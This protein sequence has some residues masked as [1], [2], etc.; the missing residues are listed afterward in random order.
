MP[1]CS[2]TIR[3]RTLSCGHAVPLPAE[4]KQTLDTIQ[5]QT[6]QTT[7]RTVA[8]L[9]AIMFLC[10]A[11]LAVYFRS[12]GGYKVQRLEMSGETASGGVEGPVR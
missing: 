1:G 5:A 2:A 11:G 6:K 10:Y 7:L 12:R 8:I 4:Q 9:P 3:R